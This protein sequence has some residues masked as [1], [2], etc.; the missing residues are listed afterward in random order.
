MRVVFRPNLGDSAFKV[1]KE[2]LVVPW[3]EQDDALLVLALPWRQT[4]YRRRLAMDVSGPFMARA[5][6]AETA[7]ASSRSIMS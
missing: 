2:F 3:I 6:P 5:T 4:L 1:A 7:P